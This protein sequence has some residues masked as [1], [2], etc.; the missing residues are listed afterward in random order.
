M[1]QTER[2]IVVHMPIFAT[3]HLDAQDNVPLGL[4]E[5]PLVWA[6]ISEQQAPSYSNPG[7]PPVF[8]FTRQIQTI[9]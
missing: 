5:K 8:F 4:L 9:N 3:T 7:Y 2:N 1:L 6:R